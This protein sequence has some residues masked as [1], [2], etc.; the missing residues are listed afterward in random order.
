MDAYWAGARLEPACRLPARRPGPNYYSCLQ[1]F[2]SWDGPQKQL[3]T[4]WAN[5]GCSSTREWTWIYSWRKEPIHA[6]APASPLCLPREQAFMKMFPQNHYNS[7]TIPSSRYLRHDCICCSANPPPNQ[8][9]APPPASPISRW[10]SRARWRESAVSAFPLGCVERRLA[11]ASFTP[12]LHRQSASNHHPLWGEQPADLQLWRSN[13]Q[14][15]KDE[16]LKRNRE[17]SSGPS[18]TCKWQM[19]HGHCFEVFT[20]CSFQP[21]FPI[22]SVLLRLLKQPQWKMSIFLCFCLTH[23]RCLRISSA[24]R[25]CRQCRWLRNWWQLHVLSASCQSARSKQEARPAIT[26]RCRCLM[27]H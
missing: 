15:E 21:P 19:M 16:W 3:H 5:R 7:I 12:V 4:R 10:C 6:R 11:A 13:L 14:G 2:I 25:T 8:R 17:Q 18:H 24:Q 1:T 9:G 20:G 27:R 22:L 23:F 26:A